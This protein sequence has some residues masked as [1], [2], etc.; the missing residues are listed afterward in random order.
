MSQ[1]AWTLLSPCLLLAVVGACARSRTPG[2][3]DEEVVLGISAP[4]SGPAAAWSAIAA[5]AQGWAAHVDAQGGV[6]GR[7]IRVVVKDDGYVPGRAVANLTEMKDSVF[8]LVAAPLGTAVANANKDLL[9]EAGLPVVYP[10][11]NPRVWA[12]QSKDK[13]ERVFVVYPDYENEGAFL[14]EQASKLTAA[15]KVAVFYQND[16]YGRDGLAGVK[17]GLGSTGATLLAEVPYELQD[18]DMSI[19]ALKFKDSGADTLILYSTTTHG[20]NLVKE[21]AKVGYRPAMFASFPLGDHL[22]MFRLLGELWEG[23]YFT[24]YG[25]VAGEPAANRVIDVLLRQNPELKG[26]ELFA[27]Y[28][29]MAMALAVEGLKGAGPALTRESFVR[30]MEGIRDWKPEGLEATITFGPGRHHGLN[31]VRL[32]RAGQAADNSFSVVTGFQ[33]FP[34]LF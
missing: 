6:H 4:L 34:P 5:G 26:R 9:A 22:V 12:R 2:V 31:G 24:V 33:S 15:K 20:A 10:F 8:A 17:R 18:R 25:P 27:V 19:H 21:M 29:A 23:V 32:L 16:D 30:A 11:A 7:Q 14:A 28:G 3:T 1:R 13:I